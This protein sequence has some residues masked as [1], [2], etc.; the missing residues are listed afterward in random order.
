[1]WILGTIGI[2]LAAIAAIA[3]YIALNA[4][5][6]ML[7]IGVIH[8]EWLTMMPT[9]GYWASVK[10]SAMLTLCSTIG[11]GWLFAGANN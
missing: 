10:V 9:I 11:L 7:T 3:G 1:M 2:F 5:I 8:N 4:W 6:F